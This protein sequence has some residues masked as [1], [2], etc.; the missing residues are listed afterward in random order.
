[1]SRFQVVLQVIFMMMFLG[2]TG[3]LCDGFNAIKPILIENGVYSHLCKENEKT[4]SNQELRLNLIY[5]VA[6]NIN[7]ICYFIYGTLVD[8]IHRRFV[9]LFGLI[10]LLIGSITFP[11]ADPIKF[12]VYILAYLLIGIGGS[13]IW[14]VSLT[15]INDTDDYKGVINGFSNSMFSLS[16]STF[17]VFSFIYYNTHITLTSIFFAYSFFTFCFGLMLFFT[18]KKQKMPDTTFLEKIKSLFPWRE[19][20]SLRFILFAIGFSLQFISNSFYF[21]TVAEHTENLIGK[22]E[23]FRHMN[24]FSV[25]LPIIGVTSSIIFGYLTDKIPIWLNYSFYIL[26][27][28]LYTVFGQIKNSPLQYV[29]YFLFLL[30]YYLSYVFLTSLIFNLYNYNVAPRIMTAIMSLGGLFGFL[31][32]L[33]NYLVSEKIISYFLMNISLGIA[34][35]LGTIMM[36]IMSKFNCLSCQAQE[37]SKENINE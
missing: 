32:F 17:I 20:L 21:S 2:F 28:I 19:M 33:L 34:S 15:Y 37:E 4:C 26:I 16:S 35:V 6:I 27:T 36:I 10:L 25:L 30:K 3:G 22:E 11:L 23:T 14:I 9:T 31:T 1:M 7:S 8:T 18:M 12:D 5:I 13:T 24:V 29:T